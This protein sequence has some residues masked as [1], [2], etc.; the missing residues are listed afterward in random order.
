MQL[1][2]ASHALTSSDH[3]ASSAHSPG[4]RAWTFPSY[5]GVRANHGATK[6]TATIAIFKHC[7]NENGSDRLETKHT[8]VEKSKT[9]TNMASPARLVSSQSLRRIEGHASEMAMVGIRFRWLG[10]VPPF[11]GGWD[12]MAW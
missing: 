6:V 3:E 7:S 4:V 11:L 9:S 8:A 2:E 1:R 10:Y 12:A 5:H